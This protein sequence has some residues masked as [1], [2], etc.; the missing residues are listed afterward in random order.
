MFIGGVLQSIPSPLSARWQI[1][2]LPVDL[3][4]NPKL[5]CS[6]QHVGRFLH[7]SGEDKDVIYGVPPSSLLLRSLVLVVN[8]EAVSCASIIPDRLPDFAASIAFKSGVLGWMVI[9]QWESEYSVD[10]HDY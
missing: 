10:A 5:R 6:R 2:E 1:H 4:I 3:S 7:Y 9:T 8:N